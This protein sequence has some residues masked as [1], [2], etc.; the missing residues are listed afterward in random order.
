MNQNPQTDVTSKG[1][2]QKQSN[3]NM[4]TQVSSLIVIAASIF[5]IGPAATA[6]TN[7]WLLKER[8]ISPAV[9][10]LLNRHK[11]TT[12]EQRQE[13]IQS[14]CNERTLPAIDCEPMGSPRSRYRY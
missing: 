1:M 7:E 8:L 11:A 13:V 5:L 10:E 3:A 14:A 9:Y 12:R 6:Y 2:P 4:I